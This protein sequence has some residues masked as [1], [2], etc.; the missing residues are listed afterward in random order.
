MRRTDLKELIDLVAS[1]VSEPEKRLEKVYD[2]EAARS[3]EIIK[4]V[5]GFAGTLFVAVLVALFQRHIEPMRWQ[6]PLGISTALL[7]A[8]YAVYRLRRL[9]RLQQQFLTA[10][11]LVSE[12]QKIAP[13]IRAYRKG[14]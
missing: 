8:T 7:T 11:L 4:W 3:L 14:P 1:G 9:R 6:F 5:L 13:F 12:F 10:V 2:W